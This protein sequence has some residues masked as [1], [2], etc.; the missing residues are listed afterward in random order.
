M[1]RKAQKQA[2]KPA[3]VDCSRVAD[4]ALFRA[5]V[6]NVRKRFLPAELRHLHIGFKCTAGVVTV[7]GWVPGDFLRARTILV[8]KEASP[9]VKRIIKEKFFNFEAGGCDE[10]TQKECNGGCIDK[11]LQCPRMR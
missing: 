6:R 11:N 5:I 7:Q 1:S 8:I 9:C 10:E 3:K 2:S 4:S